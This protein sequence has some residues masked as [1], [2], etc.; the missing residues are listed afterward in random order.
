MV[1]WQLKVPAKGSNHQFKCLLALAPSPSL[2]VC[3]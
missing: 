1:V 3:E 2:V